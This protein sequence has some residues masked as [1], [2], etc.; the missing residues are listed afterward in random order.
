MTTLAMTQADQIK[1]HLE[2]GKAITPAQSMLVYGISRLS[3]VIQRLRLKGMDIVTVP[4]VDEMGRQYGEYKLAAEVKLHCKVTIK[5]GHG[6]GLPRWVR[7]S[8]AA[9]VV[10]LAGDVAYVEFIRGT[11]IETHPM[12]V[13]E[14]VRVS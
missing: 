6:W 3:S 9:R 10:G 14:L 1:R 12:N 7:K 5:P 13:K 11:H 4:K 2:T 8:K